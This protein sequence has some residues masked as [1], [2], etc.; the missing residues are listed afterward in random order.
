VE[1]VKRRMR[2]APYTT[3]DQYC[4]QLVA[5]SISFRLA[6]TLGN[7]HTYEEDND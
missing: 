5:L 1:T 4:G 2:A 7:T 3:A 6:R